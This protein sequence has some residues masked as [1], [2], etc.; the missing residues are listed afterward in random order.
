MKRLYTKKL[1][2]LLSLVLQGVIAVAQDAVADNMLLYQRMIGGWP[3]HLNNVKIDYNKILSPGNKAALLDDKYRNDATIDNQATQKE[4]RYL[5]KAYQ[6]TGNKAYYAA[7]ENGVRYL[8]QM[9]HAGGGF[10][11][12]YPDTSL[13][14]AQITYNDD[15]MI[16]ALNILYDVVN[17]AEGFG[18]FS[19][20]LRQKSKVAV[21]KGLECI[22][23]TQIKIGD[24]LT[25]WCAQHDRNTL[26]PVNARSFELAS[27]SGQETVGIVKFLMKV[28]QPSPAIITAV[29]AAVQWLNNVKIEGY[30]VKVVDDA[31]QPK[32][33]DR[34]LV[35]EK[36]SVIWARFYDLETGKPFFCGRDGIK[37]E[38]LA[39][40]EYERRNG[41]AWY[42]LW[43]AKLI[44]EDYPAWK[45][46]HVKG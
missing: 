25:G 42:G 12:F 46:K 44:N 33:K 31:T 13:Y 35:A 45:A 26:Q 27:L 17:K 36:G 18:D 21:D 20:D 40:I 15:A 14:R 38:S 3:K 8:L 5:L 43:P 6:R 34:V 19:E 39:A 16:N 32:G 7:A 23:K 24:K 1:V 41:Y 11:Q 30:T 22:V 4:I 10:P 9:Q 29:Q 28:K 37:Q 2:L